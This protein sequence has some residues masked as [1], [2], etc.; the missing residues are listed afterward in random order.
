MLKSIVRLEA[1][2]NEGKQDGMQNDWKNK[3]SLNMGLV[4]LHP[5]PSE[6]RHQLKGTTTATALTGTF[7]SHQ[8]HSM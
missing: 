6:G 7:I 2:D 4:L 1:H 5:G 8:G 3:G